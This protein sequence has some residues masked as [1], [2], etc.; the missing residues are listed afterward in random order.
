MKKRLFTLF[1]ILISIFSLIA[2]GNSEEILNETNTEVSTKIETNSSQTI[3]N[4]KKDMVMINGNLYVRTENEYDVL[5]CG[6]M[7][8]EITSTVDDSEIPTQDNQSNFGE[9]YG[10]QYMDE[11]NVNIYINKKWIRFE[12]SQ[13]LTP[14]SQN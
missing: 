1:S 13:E 6:M 7:D 5:K 10:Y 2:C 9:G 3:N 14:T 11:N 8:G 4:E 12:K